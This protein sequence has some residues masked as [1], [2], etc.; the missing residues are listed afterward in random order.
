MHEGSDHPCFT[1]TRTAFPIA[2]ARIGSA[3]KTISSILQCKLYRDDN[4]YTGDAGAVSFDIHIE[5]DSFG[6]DTEFA[7]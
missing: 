5:I 3:G 6:S 1:S 2:A 7:K 4:V